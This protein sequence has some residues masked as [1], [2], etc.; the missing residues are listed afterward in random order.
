M[1]LYFDEPNKIK[2]FLVAIIYQMSSLKKY[3]FLRFA[4]FYIVYIPQN[5]L[6]ENT[7]L[8]LKDKL[9]DDE[10]CIEIF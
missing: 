3:L 5:P 1:F 2:I 4:I 10:F 7:E 9:P 8:F 6:Q